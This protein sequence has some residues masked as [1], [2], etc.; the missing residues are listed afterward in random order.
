M[1]TFDYSLS[2]LHVDYVKLDHRWNFSHVISPYYRIYYID[3]GEGW[4]SNLDDKILLEPGY[5]YMIPSFTLCYLKCEKY[6]GQYFV[7]FFEDSKDGISLFEQ[8]R[9]LLKVKAIESDIENF[10]RL[11]EINKNRGIKRSND[12]KVY[13]KNSFYR[14][15]QKLNCKQD[16]SSY[17]ETQAILLQL[18][19]KFL[20]LR[21][22]KKTSKEV[23]VKIMEA[24]HYIQTHL[25]QQISVHFLAGMVNQHPDYFSRLFAQ[26]TGDRP[27]NYIN[28]KRIERAQYLITTSSKSLEEI[29]AE[30]GFE[31][32]PYFF[33]MFKKFTGST[34]LKYRQQMRTDN[35]IY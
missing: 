19:S 6:L 16:Q 22:V 1:R 29:A 35:M 24:I 4:I 3:G 30:S 13:E 9:K 18:L 5:L 27:I 28:E 10:K 11:L 25:H 17:F 33:K 26:F 23:P 32:M 7:Q 34:P 2:L 31:G 14:E 8:N 20:P 15:Y 12:P 21:T